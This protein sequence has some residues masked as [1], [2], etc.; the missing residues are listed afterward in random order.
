MLLIMPVVVT[1]TLAGGWQ[2]GHL[3]GTVFPGGPGHDWIVAS[4]IIV[5]VMSIIALG[6]LEPANV[7]VLFELKKPRPNGRSW[8]VGVLVQLTVARSVR[9]AHH[10]DA[11]RR[12]Y[13]RR[14]QAATGHRDRHG[15]LALIGAAAGSVSH[16]GARVARPG[17]RAARRVGDAAGRQL[18]RV[19]RR[20]RGR[21]SSTLKWS[22][23]AARSAGLIGYSSPSTTSRPA[24]LVL[25]GSLVITR[26]TSI[27]SGSPSRAT[28]SRLVS[29]PVIA[30][31]PRVASGCV[32]GGADSASTIGVANVRERGPERD[33]DIRVDR[34]DRDRGDGQ[35]H[36]ARSGWPSPAR[37]RAH[38]DER[39]E[40]VGDDAM[41]GEIGF[42]RRWGR[43][44][45]PGSCSSDEEPSASADSGGV[46]LRLNDI[47]VAR[48]CRTTGPGRSWRLLSA[49]RKFDPIACCRSPDCNPAT[50]AHSGAVGSCRAAVSI[51]T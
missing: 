2:L 6:L 41:C 10:D 47:V 15:V 19:E 11:V 12:S 16:R 42:G 40:R 49:V 14:A 31:R 33:P 17:G 3:T 9:D 29:R 43:P 50:A 48:T 45:G 1:M 7:A 36:R 46:S 22:L 32:R 8:T 34:W 25:V 20:G 5:G 24:L 51:E 30:T 44:T 4:Y 18:H 27:W 23:L 35:R 37:M 26:C 38:S 13:E 28:T 39:A 21:S